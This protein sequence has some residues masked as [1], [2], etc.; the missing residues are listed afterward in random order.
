M[1]ELFLT[2][3][4]RQGTIY[5][6]VFYVS[7]FIKNSYFRDYHCGSVGGRQK[8]LARCGYTRFTTAYIH[9]GD[10]LALW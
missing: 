7:I 9:L 1:F 5:L 4:A 10:D 3:T 2:N 8:I 6:Y